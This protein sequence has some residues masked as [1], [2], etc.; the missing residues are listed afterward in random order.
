MNCFNCQQYF[1]DFTDMELIHHIHNCLTLRSN[2][3]LKLINK[4]CFCDE[5]VLCFP[6]QSGVFGHLELCGKKNNINIDLLCQIIQGTTCDTN[7]NNYINFD[8]HK[9]TQQSSHNAY[10]NT[11]T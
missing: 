1:L 9:N 5:S 3:T 7:N 4:C 6:T 10:E 8:E 11:R 2:K